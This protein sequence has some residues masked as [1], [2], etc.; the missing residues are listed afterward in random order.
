MEQG[1]KRN[2]ECPG[3]KA[4]CLT[5]S[6][7]LPSNHPLRHTALGGTTHSPTH[8]HSLCGSAEACSASLL[9]ILVGPAAHWPRLPVRAAAK[10]APGPSLASHPPQGPG[11]PRGQAHC[12]FHGDACTLTSAFLHPWPNKEGFQVETSGLKLPLLLCPR[13]PLGGKTGPLPTAQASSGRGLLPPDLPG[14]PFPALT[15][16]LSK[17]EA[18]LFRGQ[19][20]P[21]LQPSPRITSVRWD[22]PRELT[23][24]IARLLRSH[25]QSSAEPGSLSGR[26]M[27]GQTETLRNP[28][29][30]TSPG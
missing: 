4:C 8:I 5:T 28:P 23:A 16:R 15:A 13:W 3:H 9:L 22:S 6:G 29:P 7:C 25:G 11:F 19:A 12:C 20:L 26:E 21:Q 24:S 18:C 27:D 14:S 10:G 2:W 17:L 30:R 1:L